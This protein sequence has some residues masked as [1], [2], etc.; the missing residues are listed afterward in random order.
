MSNSHSDQAPGHNRSHPGDLGSSGS[1]TNLPAS[2]PLSLTVPTAMEAVLR[3]ADASTAPLDEGA[4]WSKQMQAA[5][6]PKTSTPE[7]RTGR[8]AEIAAWRFM[9]ADGTECEP[10]GIYWGPLASGTLADGRTPFYS[11]T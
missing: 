1:V 2:R 4:L 10:W 7:E 11:P 6:D 9:R 8:F 3:E 5:P